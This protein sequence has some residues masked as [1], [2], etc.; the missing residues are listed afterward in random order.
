M[1]KGKVEFNFLEGCILDYS[2]KT[3]ITAM[4]F[5]CCGSQSVSYVW[6][7]LS[8]GD[9]PSGI[10]TRGFVIPHLHVDLPDL[11]TELHI[12]FISCTGLTMSWIF[13]LI[14]L[15]G[16]SKCDKDILKQHCGESR[17][18]TQNLFNN[19]QGVNQ[20]PRKWIL[21]PILSFWDQGLANI[22]LQPLMRTLSYVTASWYTGTFKE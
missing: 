7:Y 20:S 2:I 3:E 19:W 8:T 6:L 17:W 1:H 5:S 14:L 18:W 21:Q 13:P 15:W 11:M 22:W 16:E 12:C 10:N 4:I 9:F